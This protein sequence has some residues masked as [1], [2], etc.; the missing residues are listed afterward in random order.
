MLVSKKC[1]MLLRE[2]ARETNHDDGVRD[3]REHVDLVLEGEREDG[4]DAAEEVD[5]HERERDA[6]NRA[7]LVDLIKLRTL[8][9]AA[10]KTT[11]YVQKKGKQGF[12]CFWNGREGK[13]QRARQPQPNLQKKLTTHIRATEIRVEPRMPKKRTPVLP[14]GVPRL[15]AG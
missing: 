6:E 13:G 2:V 8:G 14:A 5:G 9:G 12:F 10:D 15:Y 3:S 7:V 4:E 1:H 11:S